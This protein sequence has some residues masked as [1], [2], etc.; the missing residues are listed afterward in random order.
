M[1]SEYTIYIYNIYIYI[2]LSESLAF[3][4]FQNLGKKTEQMLKW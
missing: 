1:I 3:F 2:Y 4:W